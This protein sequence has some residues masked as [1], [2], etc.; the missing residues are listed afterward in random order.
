M[1]AYLMSSAI[2]HDDAHFEE[3]AKIEE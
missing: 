3:L 2:P 1:P